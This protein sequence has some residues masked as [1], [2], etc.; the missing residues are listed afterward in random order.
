ML[1]ELRNIDHNRRKMLDNKELTSQPECRT[2]SS[3]SSFE[4][5]Q[6]APAC[7]I[8]I[9]VASQVPSFRLTNVTSLSHLLGSTSA[10]ESL[11][12]FVLSLLMR[13]TDAQGQFG[14]TCSV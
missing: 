3:K 13:R 5:S 2:I 8:L 10:S 4:I 9:C 11:E 12:R 7:E 1:L 14:Q 6:A